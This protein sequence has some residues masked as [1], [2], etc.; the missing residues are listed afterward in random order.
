MDRET[1][2]NIRQWLPTILAVLVVLAGT[3]TNLFLIEQ[4]AGLK[5]IS[6]GFEKVRGD[7]GFAKWSTEH[8]MANIEPNALFAIVNGKIVGQFHFRSKSYRTLQSAGVSDHAQR[9]WINVDHS[10][11]T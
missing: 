3:I 2:P 1:K 6:N 8:Q 5:T 10:D 9:P 11:G 7:M 4:D